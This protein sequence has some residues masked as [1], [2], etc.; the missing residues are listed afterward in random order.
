V[1]LTPEDLT[2]VLDELV[3]D[4]VGPG[5]PLVASAVGRAL[6]PALAEHGL[7]ATVGHVTAAVT[8]AVA[9]EAGT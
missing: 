2:V 5:D 1:A 3:L 4:G 9:A 8:G 7:E 6:A